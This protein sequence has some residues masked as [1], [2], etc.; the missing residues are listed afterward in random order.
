MAGS[1]V[2]KNR[3]P[4]QYPKVSLPRAS[5]SSGIGPDE[6]V[7]DSVGGE[8]KEGR[9]DAAGGSTAWGWVAGWNESIRG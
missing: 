5:G 7:G 1:T 9:D 6:S 3:L 2:G 8:A 4:G